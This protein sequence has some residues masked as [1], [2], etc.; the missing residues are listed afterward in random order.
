MRRAALSF[1]ATAMSTP[2][3]SC[4]ALALLLAACGGSDYGDPVSEARYDELC[5]SVCDYEN[6]CEPSEPT[7][8]ACYD[9]CAMP[10]ASNEALASGAVEDLVSC[11]L[12]LSCTADGGNCLEDLRIQDYQQAMLDACEASLDRCDQVGTCS[13]ASLELL[14]QPYCDAL[15]ACFA[16]PCDDRAACFDTVQ[17]DFGVDG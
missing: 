10:A 12:A 9:D 2:Q 14:S 15:A 3:R 1:D 4:L 13:F 8:T 7:L 16:E 5:R 11:R 17:A 6:D